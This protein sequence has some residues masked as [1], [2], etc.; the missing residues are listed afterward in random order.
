MEYLQRFVEPVTIKQ[1]IADL[2]HHSLVKGW[3]HRGQQHNL[4]ASYDKVTFSVVKFLHG[5]SRLAVYVQ[6]ALRVIVSKRA[7]ALKV[8]G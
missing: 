3:A 5:H 2:I 8:A 6:G 7:C 4:P 1:S